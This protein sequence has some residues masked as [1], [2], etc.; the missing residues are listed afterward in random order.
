MVGFLWCLVQPSLENGNIKFGCLK[1]E[2]LLD[3]L[4]I[5]VESNPFCD[6]LSG[7]PITKLGNKNIMLEAMVGKSR[8]ETTRRGAFI[9]K[10]N[11]VQKLTW[12]SPPLRELSRPDSQ[13]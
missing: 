11:P 5:V 10:K 12:Q 1:M 6:T 2:P 3:G 8:N 7:S 9:Q 4:K 13:K